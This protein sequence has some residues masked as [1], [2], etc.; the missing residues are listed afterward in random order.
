MERDCVFCID[1]GSRSSHGVDSQRVVHKYN[2]WWLV[3]QREDKLKS[4]KQAAGLLIPTRHFEA[5]TDMSDDEA[6]ELKNIIKDASSRLCAHVGAIYA[7]QETVGFNQGTEAGQTVMHAH[8]HI[9]PVAESD[10]PE[11]KDRGGIGGAFEALREARLGL[12]ER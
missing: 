2:H 4:T 8:V 5:A 6:I 12:R 1:P 3:I 11:L 10:P 7:N 9:L